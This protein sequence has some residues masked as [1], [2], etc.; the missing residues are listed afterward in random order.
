[1]L[2]VRGGFAA[3]GGEMEDDLFLMANLRP[4]ETGLPMVWV[5]ER[6]YARHG[7]RVKVSRTHGDRIDPTNT[8]SVA[9]D[10]PPRVASGQLSQADLR[11]VS[12]WVRLNEAVILDYW[13][14]AISTAE[15]LQRLRRLP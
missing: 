15:M 1:M 8:A 14:S 12:E 10:R 4:A 7:A 3:W 5:S 13:D 11:A 6:G 2:C 9:I